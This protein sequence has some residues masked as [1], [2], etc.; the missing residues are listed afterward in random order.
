MDFLVT[1]PPLLVQHLNEFT[2]RGNNEE[3]LDF[4]YQGLVKVIE[5]EKSPT[6]LPIS[7]DT[8]LRIMNKLIK[9]IGVSRNCKC[10][11]QSYYV[12]AVLINVDYNNEKAVAMALKWLETN[13]APP[14]C[15]DI[16]TNRND[17]SNFDMTKLSGGSSR[18][19]SQPPLLLWTRV[20]EGI[21]YSSQQ[22]EEGYYPSEYCTRFLSVFM[23]GS[24]ERQVAFF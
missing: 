1:F 5:F 12:L 21:M 17:K 13:P 10:L 15:S 20:K 11:T 6:Q 16:S 8:T 14:N 23:Q 2:I 9:N 19:H 4:I 7:A 24:A 22:P 3:V 18:T